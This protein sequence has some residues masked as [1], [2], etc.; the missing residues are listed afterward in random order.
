MNL[1]K[2]QRLLQEIETVRDWTREK[3]SLLT[4]GNYPAGWKLLVLVIFSVQP[5]TGV[6]GVH[7]L[8]L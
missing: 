5:F 6:F 7:I 1:S 8:V 4:Q 3:L 2:L